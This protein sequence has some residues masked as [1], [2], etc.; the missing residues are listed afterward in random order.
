M[1]AFVGRVP[2]A[3]AISHSRKAAC[4]AMD[5]C[6]VSNVVVLLLL[7]MLLLLMLWILLVLLL[8]L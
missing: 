7:L 8:W 1:V 3:V 2:N 5:V 4:R 6:L